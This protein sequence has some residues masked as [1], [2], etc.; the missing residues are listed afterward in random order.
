METMTMTY[1]SRPGL[2]QDAI[3]LVRSY[4]L[5]GIL[6]CYAQ[7]CK[8]QAQNLNL[9]GSDRTSLEVL[10]NLLLVAALQADRTPRTNDGLA[11]TP[12][13]KLRSK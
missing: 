7:H 12:G 3:A 2:E 13:I 11:S 1:F 6:S 4:G 9:I 10:S 5:S 8:N